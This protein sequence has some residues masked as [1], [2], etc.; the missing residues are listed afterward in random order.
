MTST[1]QVS[2]ITLP[3]SSRSTSTAIQRKSSTMW[4]SW[5]GMPAVISELEDDVRHISA[6]P[7]DG[8]AGSEGLVPLL[9]AERFNFRTFNAQ[10]MLKE[11]AT[12]GQNATVR[13]FLE[14]GVPLTPLPAPKTEAKPCEWHSL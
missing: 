13:Q 8:I 11:A 6:Y 7:T 9:Q 12:R 14:A 4:V 5:V 3:L 10:V 1:L 2:R